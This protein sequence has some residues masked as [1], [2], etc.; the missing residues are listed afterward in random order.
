MTERFWTTAA[1]AVALALSVGACSYIHGSEAKKTDELLATAGF[2]PV[3]A[4]TPDK[5]AQLQTQK[6]LK[7]IARRKDGQTIYTYADPY[8]CHCMWVG[9]QDQYVTYERLALDQRIAKENLETSEAEEDASTM[10]WAPWGI[11]PWW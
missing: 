1:T 2:K 7:I 8:D 5:A 9:S 3:A 10:A 4:D 11:G 6:P